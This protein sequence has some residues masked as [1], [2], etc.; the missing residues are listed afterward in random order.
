MSTRE[1]RKPFGFRSVLE[2]GTAGDAYEYVSV[3]LPLRYYLVAGQP[4]ESGR[5][6]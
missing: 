6:E 4:T 1:N 2:G 3:R 5:K